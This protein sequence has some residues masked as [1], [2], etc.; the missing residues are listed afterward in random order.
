MLVFL[1]FAIETLAAALFWQPASSLTWWAGLRIY[2]KRRV[3]GLLRATHVA[4]TLA[5]RL[6]T[7]YIDDL[8][9]YAPL[10][11]PYSRKIWRFTVCIT[12]TKLKSTKISYSHILYQEHMKG[13]SVHLE[14]IEK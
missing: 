12:T 3:Y 10:K 9:L 5:Y 6:C 11:L 14:I 2:H 1:F 8:V 7:H 13:R 4:M